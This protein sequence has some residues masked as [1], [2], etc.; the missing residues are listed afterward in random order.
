MTRQATSPPRTIPNPATVTGATSSAPTGTAPEFRVAY[1]SGVPGVA[2]RCRV[3]QPQEQLALAGIPSTYHPAGDPGIFEDL[4][5]CDIAVFHRVPFSRMV[6]DVVD[7]VR[8]R[9]G[10]AI[11]ESDDLVFRPE[12][13]EHDSYYRHLPA[14][15]MMRHRIMV[16]NNQKT[17]R[18]CDAMLT[19]TEYLADHLR[20][21]GKPVFIHRNAVGRDFLRRAAEAETTVARRPDRIVL[22]YISGSKSHDY[23]FD[24]ISQPLL[25]VMRRHPE[26]VLRVVGDLNL[27]PT[28]DPLRGRIEV[29][30]FIPWEEVAH[31]LATMDVNLAPLEEDNPFCQSKSE[32]K[33]IEAGVLGVPTLASRTQCFTHAIRPDENG[34]LA[35]T[36]QEWTDCLERLVSDAAW[37]HALGEAARSDIQRNYDP[38]VR[39]RQLVALLHEARRMCSRPTEQDLDADS[40]ARRIIAKLVDYV[41]EDEELPIGNPAALPTSRRLRWESQARARERMVDELRRFRRGP[42]R[43][44]V[45]WVKMQA[46]A[47]A[48]RRYRMSAE[49][50]IYEVMPPLRSDQVVGQSF[51]A[52]AANLCTVDVL[53]A[54]FRRVNTPEVVFELRAAPDDNTPVA[55][56]VVSAAVLE[57]CH[58]CPFPFDP[59]SDSAGQM[60]FVT[61]AAPDAVI[62]D[63]VA[64]WT[65]LDPVE[66]DGERFVNGRRMP[67]RLAIRLRYRE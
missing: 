29:V 3:F 18:R 5:D 7:L 12:F 49:G 23:D 26:A 43:Q 46:K 67:G 65:Q 60:Y 63:T 8:R 2:L 41:S 40:N 33:Y 38:E 9:G 16:R 44:F 6:G 22:G 20:V 42:L 11:Y 32:L 48:G 1:V 52:T 50:V 28:L 34:L 56:S 45:E 53:F 31:E 66:P 35:T 10:I 55:R 19:T 17:A 4:L 51:R 37:R 30:K 57:D 14:E 58:F 25:T 24:V 64:L 62:G 54:T 36:Q 59:L 13:V 39:G 27:P 21:F 15:A 47:L 61:I